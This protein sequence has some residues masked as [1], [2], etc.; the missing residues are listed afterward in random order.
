MASVR[1]TVQYQLMR[2]PSLYQNRSDCFIHLFLTG[3]NGYFWLNGELIDM[4]E[5]TELPTEPN[6]VDRSIGDIDLQKVFKSY[7]DLE[8]ARYR[9]TFETALS[10]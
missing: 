9:F 2:Y 8:D 7:N 4:H 10:N 1:D 5:E 6:T 3:G